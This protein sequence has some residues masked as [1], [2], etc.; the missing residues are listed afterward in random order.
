MNTERSY[1]VVKKSIP[2]NG[3]DLCFLLNHTAGGKNPPPTISQIYF[4]CGQKLS[5][6]PIELVY[7]DNIGSLNHRTFSLCAPGEF[8]DLTQLFFFEHLFTGQV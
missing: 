4:E 2:M 3:D 5:P 6:T 7:F 8:V 1:G